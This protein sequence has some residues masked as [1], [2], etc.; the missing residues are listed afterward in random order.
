MA[1]D[2]ATRVAESFASR[3]SGID[4]SIKKDNPVGFGKENLAPVDYKKKL[5]G[6]SKEQRLAEI[7][8]RGIDVVANALRDE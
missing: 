6:M 3:L 5:L 1:K 8:S 7:E 4:N 2:M